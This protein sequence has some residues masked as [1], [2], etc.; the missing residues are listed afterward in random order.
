[1]GGGGGGGG[2]VVGVGYRYFAKE[3]LKTYAFLV[4]NTIR[5]VLVEMAFCQRLWARLTL[6]TSSF[7]S[8]ETRVRQRKTHTRLPFVL[9]CVESGSL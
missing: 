4:S 1:L 3:T 7:F 9:V 2:G 6:C 8:V 5:L